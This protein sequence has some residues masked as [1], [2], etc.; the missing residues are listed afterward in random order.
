MVELRNKVKMLNSNYHD[1]RHAATQEA[2]IDYKS[3]LAATGWC[4]EQNHWVINECAASH[5]TP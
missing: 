5:F 1:G 3:A 2:N 4:K